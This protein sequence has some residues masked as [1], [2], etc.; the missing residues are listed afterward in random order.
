[1][2]KGL[3][4]AAVMLAL[5]LTVLAETEVATVTVAI[6]REKFLIDGRPTYSDVPNVNPRALGML[7]NSRMVQA[8]FDDENPETR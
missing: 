3:T 2:W 6:D 1:M 5:A 4:V 7:L 8:L